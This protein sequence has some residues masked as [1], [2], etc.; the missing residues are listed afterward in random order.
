MTNLR[1]YYCPP[2][3]SSPFGLSDHNTIVV[4]PKIKDCNAT[5]KKTVKKRDRRASYKLELGRYLGSINW[6]SIL[7]EY[8]CETMWKIFHD[9]V[10]TGL[11]LLMPTTEIEISVT[12]A[13]WMT[14]RLKTLIKKEAKGV[15]HLWR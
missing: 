9:V 5:K 6:A 14:H 11:D 7:A 4:T 8:N 15:L 2:L 3:A 10:L 13:S 1:E 12:D